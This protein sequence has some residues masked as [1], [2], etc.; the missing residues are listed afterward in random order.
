MLLISLD[1]VNLDARL[2]FG[3]LFYAL[4][5]TGLSLFLEKCLERGMIFGRYGLW[6]DAV[7]R[8]AHNRRHRWKRYW[9]KPM[10]YCIYCFSQHVAWMVFFVFAVAPWYYL[11]LFWGASY[12]WLRSIQKLWAS[13]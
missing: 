1:A 5:S 13:T 9:L 8:K 6:L 10:G 3:F 4:L 11:P 2:G 7:W 12:L